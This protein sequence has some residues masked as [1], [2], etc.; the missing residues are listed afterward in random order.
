M[1]LTHLFVSAKSDG[2]EATLVQP[3]DWNDAHV[4]TGILPDPAN[5]VV[6]K[7][8]A[9]YYARN[10]TTGAIDYTNSLAAT[11]INGAISDLS[12]AGG[13]TVYLAAGTYDIAASLRPKD[14]VNIIG[15]GREA[16]ILRGVSGLT[17]TVLL[18]HTADT[19]TD[20]TWAHLTVDGNYTAFSAN[21]AGITLQSGTAR[22]HI[23]DV[24][25]R[26]TYH[27]GI[28]AATVSDVVI[29]N[30]VLTN[31]GKTSTSPSAIA[32]SSSSTHCTI[33]GNTIQDWGNNNLGRGINANACSNF[34]ITD[35]Q[36]RLVADISCSHGIAFELG[37]RATIANNQIDKTAYTG[38]ARLGAGISYDDSD[39]VTISANVIRM[40]AQNN[41]SL[42]PILGDGTQNA[43]V[44]NVVIDGDD[45]GITAWGS[46]TAIAG[47]FVIGAAHAGIS[48]GNGAS[49][50]T[51]SGNVVKNSARGGAPAASHDSGIVVESGSG[52]VITG[53]RCYDDQG[54]PTQQYGIRLFGS[55][56]NNT[57]V[58]NDV[59]GNVLGGIAVVGTSNL[60]NDNKGAAVATLVIPAVFKSPT[61][62][63]DVQVWWAPF[64]CT[65]LN[66][67][68]WQDTGTGSTVNAFKGSLASPTLFRAS[69]YTIASA[70]TVGDAGSLQNTSIAAGDKIYMRLASVSGSPNEVGIQLDLT[71]A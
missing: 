43:I 50:C 44:G 59:R 58:A 53:N 18:A 69:N 64:A 65:L 61:A 36:V 42:E 23:L 68:A 67:R 62:A 9:T 34:V 16:T 28:S 20:C 70:D 35:N 52:N 48:L 24:V 12:T 17:S 45:N 10:G 57:I 3:G 1:P 15:A 46:Q 4:L 47:N 13:G 8:G 60:I 30:C 25:V 49:N 56:D 7:S 21:V 2:G 11:V 31:C 66:L 71:R 38:S 22:L 33:R 39:N 55:S 27:Q 41:G 63:D 40:P 54:T 14:K 19:V 51:V 37:D 32:F 6:F 26:D 29:A 5:I